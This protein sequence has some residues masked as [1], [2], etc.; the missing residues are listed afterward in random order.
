MRPFS[1]VIEAFFK[2]NPC[3]DAASAKKALLLLYELMT[4]LSALPDNTEENWYKVQQLQSWTPLRFFWATLAEDSIQ[5]IRAAAKGNLCEAGHGVYESDPDVC[6]MAVM[7]VGMMQR[8]WTSG[9][10]QRVQRE[11]GMHPTLIEADRLWVVA[12]FGRFM[13]QLTARDVTEGLDLRE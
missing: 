8:L 11:L 10:P 6:K 1:E 2:E 12:G 5:S 9:D 3:E 4:E 7:N 13:P